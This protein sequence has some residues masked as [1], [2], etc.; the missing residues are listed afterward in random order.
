MCKHVRPRYSACLLLELRDERLDSL[1]ERAIFWVH[2][3]LL[4]K[5]L[6]L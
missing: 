3:W 5:F 2:W 1:Y 6:L 4:F